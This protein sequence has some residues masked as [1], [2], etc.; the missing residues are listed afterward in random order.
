[1][2]SHRPQ[3]MSNPNQVAIPPVIETPRLHLRAAAADFAEVINEA[4]VESLDA[5]RPWM[6]WVHPTPTV[7]H[8]RQFLTGAEAHS[9]ARNSFTYASFLKR[10]GRFV[11]VTGLH[12][13]DWSVPKVELGYWVRTSET[14]QGFA[15]ESV[16]ALTTLAFQT[17]KVNRVEMLIS[18]RNER[19]SRIPIRLGFVHEAT[20][21]RYD[22][23]IP[24]GPIDDLRVYAKIS[25]QVASRDG[26]R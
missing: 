20:M 21:R 11:G 26:D 5:L 14:G 22:R 24:G 17:L 12:G 19:S 6:P 25:E 4:I 1:M 3:R 18:V 13:M 23:S 15:T 2:E 7:D 8:T 16:E 9:Q 10:N